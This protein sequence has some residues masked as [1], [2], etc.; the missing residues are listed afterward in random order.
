MERV[1]FRHIS[2]SKSNQV[3]EFPLA[4]FREVVIG[5][6]PAATVRYD[7]DR[8]DLV[9]RQH[10]R[11]TRDPE[12]PY[13]FT[14]TDL[15][16]RNGTF[17][18]SQRIVGSAAVAPG[19][20]IQFGAGGPEFEFTIEPLPAQFVRA[21]RL[22][23]AAG[24]D[25]PATRMAGLPAGT[26]PSG[27]PKTAVGKAT[28]ERIVADARTQTRRSLIAGL[29][30]VALLAVAVGAYLYYRTTGQEQQIAETRTQLD[31]A[32]KAAPL[33]PQ[34]I[35]AANAEST[36][37]IEVG[38]KLIHTETG[39]QIYHEY[40]V[41]KDRQ[42]N[43]LKKDNEEVPPL[44]V[45]VRLEDGSIEPAL[46]LQE[47]Q[48]SQNK[49]IGGRHSGSGFVVTSD[50]FILTNRHVCAA[51]ETRYDLPSGPGVLLVGNKLQQIDGAPAEWVPAGAKQVGGRPASGKVVEGRNDYMDVTFAKSR[52]RTPAKLARVSDRH[53]VGLIKID[54]PQPLRKV[55][56]LDNYA[57]AQPGLAVTVMGY[58]G[59]SPEVAVL[60]RSQDRFN[61]APQ[62][63][64]VPDPTVTPG[65]IGRVLRGEVKP[66]GARENEYFSEWGDSYQLTVNATGGGNSGGP[67]FDDRGRVIAIYTAGRRTDAQISFATPIRYGLELMQVGAVIK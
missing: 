30:A 1:I 63:R 44:P 64:T 21:T 43:R 62:V 5:R 67:V 33:T 11:L 41:P 31:E 61:P 37:Y 14:L 12:D 39:G 40:Y 19:D 42:G 25:V 56:M 27:A 10:A 9:G 53:D 66:T 2:G 36:V 15:N 59:V 26:I 23:P 7:P 52:L 6:D 18:N 46:T 20:I 54:M 50:G 48:Y 13:R 28:V 60:T 38:W 34:Q 16:S 35:A 65:A 49:P 17:V 8:D 45:Y 24:A 29:A 57:E 32:M 4:D 51:W 22:A 55:E 3:E 58:P 47:G